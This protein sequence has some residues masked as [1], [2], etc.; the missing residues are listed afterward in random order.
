MHRNPATGEYYFFTAYTKYYL[1]SGLQHY[2]VCWKS[3]DISEEN[4]TTICSEMSD[5]FQ[6]TYVTLYPIRQNSSQ[7]L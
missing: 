2:V 5:H 7:P 1:L 4:A 6:Q 3:T